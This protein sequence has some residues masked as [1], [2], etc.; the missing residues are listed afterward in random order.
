MN[1]IH[2]QSSIATIITT[3]LIIACLINEKIAVITGTI[4]LLALTMS[5]IY[6]FFYNI[7]SIWN[8]ND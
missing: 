5:C 6:G 1:K 2:I 8:Q 7:L 3:V 4:I